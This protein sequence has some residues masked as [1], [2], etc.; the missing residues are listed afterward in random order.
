MHKFL[1]ALASCLFAFGSRVMA[2]GGFGGCGSPPVSCPPQT[3][4]CDNG[5][6]VCMP[7]PIQHHVFLDT[8]G[9]LKLNQCPNPFHNTYNDYAAHTENL[10]YCVGGTNAGKVFGDKAGYVSSCPGPG[11]TPTDVT[12]G[13]IADIDVGPIPCNEHIYGSPQACVWDMAKSNVCNIHAGTYSKPGARAGLALVT[14]TTGTCD[15]SECWNATIG[16]WGNGPNMGAQ[17][18]TGYGTADRPGVVR[19]AFMYAHTDTWDQDH[20]KIPDCVGNTGSSVCYGECTDSVPPGSGFPGLLCV[21][22]ADCPAAGDSC[23]HTYYS[24]EPTSYP[25]IMD[26][27]S[28]GD[29]TYWEYTSCTGATTC[30]GDGFY[31]VFWGCG[32]ENDDASVCPSTL[33]GGQHR[34]Y[35]DANADGQFSSGEE[36]G[37]AGNWNASYLT[38]RDLEFRHYNG[39]PASC[40]S[41][42]IREYIGIIQMSGGNASV[43]T[44]GMV[45]DHPFFH[46]N[47]YSNGCDSSHEAFTAIIGDNENHYSTTADL[48]ENGLVIQGGKFLLND[49]CGEYGEC[50][51][52][53][54]VFGNRIVFP[55]K[56]AN[57][58]N[59]QSYNASTNPNGVSNPNGTAPSNSAWQALARI[60][61]LDSVMDGAA[62]KVHRF[63]NNEVIIQHVGGGNFKTQL[64]QDECFGHCWITDVGYNNPADFHTAAGKGELWFYGNIVRYQGRVTAPWGVS[65]QQYCQVD[66]GAAVNCPLCPGANDN[67]KGWRWYN[68]N[69]TY[70]LEITSGTT[71][72]RLTAPCKEPGIDFV[73]RNNAYYGV[74]NLHVGDPGTI[75][76]ATSRDVRGVTRCNAGSCVTDALG[77]DICS[78]SNTS[79][80]TSASGRS[81]WWASH[82]KNEGVVAGIDNYVPNSAPGVHPL[83]ETGSCD[84]DGDGI[85]GVDYDGDGVSEEFW[86]D[87]AGN[88]VNCTGSS[89]LDIGAVQS[90][91]D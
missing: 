65:F 16:A 47:A 35:I 70:D 5:T 8:D 7:N 9:D 85:T 50:G 78:T 27:N 64:I 56:P 30:A 46:E 67:N 54:T 10:K 82:T 74:N 81:T 51:A 15:R 80:T 88:Y 45:V 52:S 90:T 53:K 13:T 59:W 11:G 31:G 26:G 19:G 83:F 36:L 79:C 86:W 71:A 41:G 76:L 84:P 87:I 14:P 28:D 72:S 68:F 4:L 2:G 69:N 25:A 63:G 39:G 75:G 1:M 17:P 29:A 89:P 3:C 33:A 20:D 48:F 62:K 57:F 24:G 37:P 42:G 58:A 40:G 23:D 18:G 34:V 73:S 77:A 66:H 38:V 44:K 49:D 6:W 21:V 32:H 60:K 55:A 22:D 43:V 61:T 12:N 91:G